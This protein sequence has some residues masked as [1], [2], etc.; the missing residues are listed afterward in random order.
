LLRHL[1]VA[2]ALLA[3]GCASAASPPDPSLSALRLPLGPGIEAGGPAGRLIFR[4]ALHLT[5]NDW[6]FGGLSGLHV[7]PDGHVTSVSDNGY[8]VEFDVVEE[9]G[10]LRD[11]TRLKVEQMQDTA[12]RPLARSRD[13]DAEELVVLPD[14][15]RLVVFER[16]VRL[17]IFPPGSARAERFI[18]LPGLV[19]P[20]NRAIEAMV[21]FADDRLLLIA[22]G[23]GEEAG[24]RRAWIGRPGAWQS[25]DYVPDDNEDVS[26]A[27]LLPD[28]DLLVLE[29]SFT[30]IPGFGNRLK[31]VPAASMEPGAR[32][33]GT[34]LLHLV[35]PWLNDNFEGVAVRV[36]NGRTSIYLISDD[37]YFALQRTLLLKFDLPEPQ[38]PE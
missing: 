1:L 5:S 3:S 24:V 11:A 15:R 10:E 8:F 33:E 30:I 26:G 22:E 27:A 34:L 23:K 18:P 4:G 25:L 13:R 19:P 21:R 29:R 14:G 32:L 9:S 35:P 20:T 12:G 37:N 36:A 17:G 16:D 38:A 28:G 2:I 7:A 31:R 6:R